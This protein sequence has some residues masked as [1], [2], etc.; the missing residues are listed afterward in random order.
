MDGKKMKANRKFIKDKEAVSAVIGVILMVAI[1]VAI[2]GVLWGY[3]SG[4]FGPI[5]KTPEVPCTYSADNKI[6]TVGT[7]SEAGLK[8]DDFTLKLY[9]ISAGTDMTAPTKPSGTVDAGDI[10][11]VSSVASGYTYKFT[12]VYNPTGGTAFTH[13]WTQT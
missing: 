13:E 9:N 5:T 1:T 12:I 4:F 8:W 10:I 11:S 6:F 2:V 3:L 7:P